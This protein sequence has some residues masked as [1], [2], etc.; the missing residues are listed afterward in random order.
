MNYESAEL[1][2]I[3]INLLLS[4]SINTSNI[5]AEICEKIDA[6]WGTIVPALQL[7]RRIGKHAYIKPGLGISGGNLERDIRTTIEM[8]KKY[9]VESNFF[10]S[11][12][13]Y[14]KKRK[15]WVW[16]KLVRLGVTKKKGLRI[17]VL[18]LAYK[19]NTN[20]I[21]N[22]AAIALIKKLIR[23]HYVTAYDPAASDNIRSKNFK[24]T[25]SS[26]EAINNANV[27]ILMTPWSEFRLI[28]VKKLANLMQG[29]TIIDPFKVL[30][31]KRV[32]DSSKNYYSLGN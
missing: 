16:E 19:E 27:V 6:N 26:M 13:S 7:D 10:K 20:S 3:S 25:S 21:K 9:E 4:S 1:A 22:S 2:K 8:T 32:L 23:R 14:S 18:G 12:L 28:N 11:I 17:A 31:K 15:N 30:D 29:K 5:L 24:R